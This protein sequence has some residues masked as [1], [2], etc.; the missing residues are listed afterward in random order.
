M[1]FPLHQRH[2]LVF[3]IPSNISSQQQKIQEDLIKGQ[4]SLEGEG[5]SPTRSAG[6][7]GRKLLIGIG[8][9]HDNKQKRIVR[10]E[11]EKQ[12]RKEM[13]DL[14]AS[15][16]SQLPIEYIKG[17]R[18]IS[19]HMH[20][21][22]NYIKLLQ[23]KIN[24]LSITRDKLKMLENSIGV[25]SASGSSNNCLPNSVMVSPCLGGLEILISCGSSEDV[26]PLSKVLQLL[27]L[28]EG[29][30]V[31]SCVST[32]A[33]ERLLHTIQSEVS[34]PTCIDL[35]VLQQKLTDLISGS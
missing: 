21:A 2:E 22:V 26:F 9:D 1:M 32:K 11:I 10:K 28:E 15:L 16:R 19:D 13:T 24:E 27:L 34:D 25:G 5:S 20:G 35:S 12:R 29:L 3:Q 7:R 6:K 31:I 4:A 33:N 17:K 23:K 8:D 30:T 14:Y 18:S